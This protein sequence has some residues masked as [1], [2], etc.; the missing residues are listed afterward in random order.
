[1]VI[2]AST[3]KIGATDLSRKF[4]FETEA[5]VDFVISVH[6]TKASKV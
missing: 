5:K 6:L 2:L 3:V 4:H 1:M